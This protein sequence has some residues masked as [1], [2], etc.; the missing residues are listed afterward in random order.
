LPAT[1]DGLT[2]QTLS[3]GGDMKKLLSV[4]ILLFCFFLLSCSDNKGA[5]EYFMSGMSKSNLH[6]YKGA[7]KDFDKAIELKPEYVEAYINRGLAKSLS[8]D[9][10][11]GIEDIDKALS[12]D[13]HYKDAYAMRG[14]VENKMGDKQGAVLDMKKAEELGYNKDEVEKAI[15]EIK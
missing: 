13:P 7:I 4:I 2:K 15:K 5:K 1:V 11:G 14:I 8:G 6:D 9:I 3:K 12:I 10:Q